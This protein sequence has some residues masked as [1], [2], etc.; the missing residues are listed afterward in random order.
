MNR[1]RGAE[2]STHRARATLALV[3]L[4]GFHGIGAVGGGIMFLIDTSGGAAGLDP[5][6]L[7]RTPF[8]DFLWPGLLLSVGLGVPALVLVHGVLRRPRVAVLGWIEQLTSQHW[9]WAGSRLLGVALVV[10]IAVQV[11]LIEAS[12][13]QPLML[14]IGAALVVLP[15]TAGVR[16]DLPAAAVPRTPRQPSRSTTVD[17]PRWRDVVPAVHPAVYAVDLYWLPLGAGA[18]VV[19]FTGR[20]YEWIQALVHRRPRAELY[21]AALEVRVPEGRFVVELT[22]VTAGDPAE[23]GAV[24]SGPVGSRWLGRSRLFRYELHRWRDGVIPDV[25][26]SVASP[27]RATGDPRQVR[28]LLDAV[29]RVPTPVWGRD[30]LRTGEMWNSNSVIAW[31]I[32]SSGVPTSLITPPPGGRAPGWHAGLVLAERAGDRPAPEADGPVS[33][34]VGHPSL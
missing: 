7:A 34:P 29:T 13:L 11:L 3:G 4:L 1:D 8:D 21:H 33:G 27:R 18:S 28:Q 23:R 31:L 10:W 9:A 6:L 2:R 25:D 14:L 30:E 12:L 24:C 15:A 22:P 5:S 17:E 20:V 19:R 16:R 32:A 26:Q